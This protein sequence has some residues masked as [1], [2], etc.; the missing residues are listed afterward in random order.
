MADG[1]PTV[2][3]SALDRDRWKQLRRSGL[4]ASEIA[5]VLGESP[6]LSATELYAIKTGASEGDPSLDEAEHVYWGNQLEASIIEGYQHRTGRPVRRHAVLLR[7]V[8][9]PWAL[10]TLDGETGNEGGEPAW[11][12][13][14]KNIG[15]HKAAEWEEGPPRHYLLQLQQQMLVTGAEKATAAALIGGQRLVWCDVER[16]EVEIRR[17][18]RAG[19]IFWEQ[20]VEAGVC[21]KPDGSD[22]AS[23][24]L[25][26]LYRSPNPEAFVQMGGD[27]LEL[28][29]ELVGLKNARRAIEKRAAEIEN[30]IKAAIGK[31]E[32]GV[33]PNGA[34]YS[35][36]EQTRAAYA[37][38]E[39][40]YRVLRRHASAEEK[41]NK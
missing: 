27:M 22:S 39:S 34:T 31:A 40:T 36:K 32:R 17:I 14:I 35:W 10:C 33:L 4:G 6:W 37:V 24:A 5:A 25:A 11:P 23:R 20:C 29:D 28:D 13:E 8:E 30:L 3:G 21:P 18:K 26:A 1:G 9:H 38:D 15:M 2:L 41:R 19:A 12:L 7:S 16:D